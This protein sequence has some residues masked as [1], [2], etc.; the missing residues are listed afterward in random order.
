MKR[1]QCEPK[2]RRGQVQ[3]CVLHVESG[4]RLHAWSQGPLPPVEL[5]PLA[6]GVT[7]PPQRVESRPRPLARGVRAPPSGA[8]RQGSQVHGVLALPPHVESRVSPGPHAWSLGPA[9]RRVE[10]GQA[11]SNGAAGT[12][13][14]LAGVMRGPHAKTRR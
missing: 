5:G 13:P 6:L 2:V 7:P 3:A 4:L 10:L 11:G 14:S 1:A 8:W 12:S 9:P